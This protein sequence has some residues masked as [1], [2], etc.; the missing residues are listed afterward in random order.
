MEKDPL[1]DLEEKVVKS[2]CM[3]DLLGVQVARS[4]Y[5]EET[6]MQLFAMLVTAMLSRI[7]E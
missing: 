6:V 4:K 7:F 2:M 5:G 3:T 1:F